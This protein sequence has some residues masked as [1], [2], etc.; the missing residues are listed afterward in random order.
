MAYSQAP[1]ASRFELKYLIDER[2]AGAIRDFLG[3]Y[4]EPD[5][6]A[7]ADQGNA[8][9]VYS[10]YLDS[11]ALALYRQTTHGLKNRFKLRIRFYDGQP[12]SPAFLEIKRRQHDV[13][14]KERA[15][16]TRPGVRRL[17]DHGHLDFAELV[18]GNGGASR[19]MAAA[20]RFWDL[21]ASLGAQEV[22]YVT[23]VREAYVSPG[24]SQVRVTFDR[25]IRACPYDRREGLAV[26]AQGTP[27]SIG[28]VVLE[29]KFTDRFPAW[30][31]EMVRAFN[32]QRRSMAKYVH[33]VEAMGFHLG[34]HTLLEG[35]KPWCRTG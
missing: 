6:Y 18:L 20:D 23:Y 3:G 31:G 2:R 19:A 1:Q 29:L 21:R 17:L 16:T 5:A 8:Y 12:E 28:G 33:C 30:M 9:P 25:Q 13:I 35:A 34:R 24:S 4:L 26:P 15:A 14:L 22:L 10:L 11:P 7:R 27:L 32:L